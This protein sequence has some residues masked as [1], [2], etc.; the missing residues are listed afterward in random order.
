M[1][2]VGTSGIP[3]SSNFAF[4]LSEFFSKRLSTSRWRLFCTARVRILHYYYY[5]E[6]ASRGFPP[7]AGIIIGIQYYALHTK[8]R[9]CAAAPRRY[10]R[11]TDRRPSHNCTRDGLDPD[12]NDPHRVYY[13]TVVTTIDAD[14]PKFAPPSDPLT[15]LHCTRNSE[16]GF[17][18]LIFFFHLKFLSPFI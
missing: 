6:T 5:T 18:R 8:W 16:N 7:F 17:V 2:I 14:G 9:I 11:L 4:F 12:P 13:V 10:D 3:I 1:F 15:P